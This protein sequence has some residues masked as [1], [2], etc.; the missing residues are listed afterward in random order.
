MANWNIDNSHSHINFSVRHMV[1]AKTRGTFRQWSAQLALADDLVSSSVKVEVDVA[2]I[3]TGE[4]KRDAHLRSADFFDAEK[5][6]K[7]TFAS[8]RIDKTAGKLLLVG[9]LTIR[10]TTKE[11]ALEVEETGRGKDP[12]G[13]ERV[14]FS[15]TT[16]I[17]RADYG[18]T[19]NAALET[20]GVLVGDKVE[21]SIDIEAVK[22]A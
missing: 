13:N 3:D 2:S 9:D 5:H 22:Q 14:G 6:P 21:I 10:G 1:F 16:S 20:G 18:L 17:N 11:V 12:W 19:W 7:M 4:E 15:A 8:K